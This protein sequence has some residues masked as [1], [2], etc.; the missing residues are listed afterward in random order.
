MTKIPFISFMLVLWCVL[1][2]ILWYGSAFAEPVK[3][4]NGNVTVYAAKKC[5]IAHACLAIDKT[6]A[7]LRTAGLNKPVS[8]DLHI[9]SKLMGHADPEVCLGH[10][11]T[12]TR[13]THILSYGACKCRFIKN[14]FWGLT[15]NRELHNSFIIHEVAHA[16][17]E[18]HFELETQG[19]A[20]GE[21]IAYTTQ[22]ALMSDRLREDLLT[23]ISNGGFENHQEITSTFHDLSPS[24]FA[25]KAYRHFRRKENGSMFYQKLIHGEVILNGE[26]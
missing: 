8:I 23:K 7:F 24:T 22:I 20:A 5:D 1:V 11:N 14:S 26:E 17:A 3:C 4:A 12:R 6:Y 10:Y 9:V 18:A 16:I 15:F 21:Y 13:K 19:L 2:V 25:V